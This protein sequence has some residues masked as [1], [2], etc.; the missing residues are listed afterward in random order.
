M[1][2]IYFGRNV[3]GR[4]Q[5]KAGEPLSFSGKAYARPLV[6]KPPVIT[7]SGTV[8]AA[9]SRTAGIWLGSPTIAVSWWLD[10]QEVG[11]GATYTPVAQDSGKTLTVLERATDPVSG[12]GASSRSAGLVI[13]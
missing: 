5:N 13:P 10:G 12:L 3:M 2:R 9:Q 1:N 11:Q 8:G 6:T 4:V 7:G